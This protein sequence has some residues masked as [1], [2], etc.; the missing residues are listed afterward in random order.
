VAVVALGVAYFGLADSC[1]GAVEKAANMRE[2][3]L[4]RSKM[5]R[6]RLPGSG[7]CA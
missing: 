7:A 1:Y 5:M 4:M 2:Y 3:V 6:L